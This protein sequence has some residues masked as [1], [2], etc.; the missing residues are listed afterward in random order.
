MKRTP[1]TLCLLF[2]FLTIISLPKSQAQVGFK[3]SMNIATL[4]DSDVETDSRIG[5]SAGIFTSLDIPNSPVSIQPELLYSQKGAKETGTFNGDEYTVTT[6][7]DY[8]E[9]PVLAKFRFV[10]TEP[11]TPHVYF[12][13]YLGYNLNAKAEVEGNGGSIGG[14]IED[15]I[16]DIDF[17]MV[18]GAGLEIQ[19]FLLGVRYSPGFTEIGDES[20]NL[21]AKNS[22]ISITAGIQL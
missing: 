6:K 18:V 14:N 22:V 21:D 3:G 5:L 4:Y 16:N 7:L 9:L 19:Q 2:T 13:P 17:G 8:I 11:M 15:S 1:I 12:G 10:N 20:N